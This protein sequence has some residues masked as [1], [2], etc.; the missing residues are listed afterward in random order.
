MTANDRLLEICWISFCSLH[1]FD[2]HM[3]LHGAAKN[4]KNSIK[5]LKGILDARHTRTPGMCVL[6]FVLILKSF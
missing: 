5:W 3:S 6:H 4:N 2:K 1:F